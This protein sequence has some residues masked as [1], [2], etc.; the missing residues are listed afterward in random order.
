MPFHI[1]IFFAN[2]LYSYFFPSTAAP[3][4][5]PDNQAPA[6]GPR[7][8]LAPRGRVVLPPRREMQR[9][10]ERSEEEWDDMPSDQAEISG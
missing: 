4:P 7:V 6:A 10:E 8:Q 9:I 1:L 3:A 5:A 2:Q